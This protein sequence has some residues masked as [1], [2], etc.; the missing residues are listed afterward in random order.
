MF[1]LRRTQYRDRSPVAPE[2]QLPVSGKSLTGPASYMTTQVGPS[3]DLEG[4]PGPKLQPIVPV[5]SGNHVGRL[6]LGP[7][8]MRA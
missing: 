5:T 7:V 2:Q 1:I 3:D 6:S 8:R 4:L